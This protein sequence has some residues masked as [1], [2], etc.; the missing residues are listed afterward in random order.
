MCLGRHTGKAA[1]QY[2][3][4]IKALREY[5]PFRYT[6]PLD[7]QLLQIS[8]TQIRWIE[9]TFENVQSTF[10]DVEST[11]ENVQ[12]TFENVRLD[13][14]WRIYPSLHTPH[15]PGQSRHADTTSTSTA[16]SR[17]CRRAGVATRRLRGSGLSSSDGRAS[18]SSSSASYSPRSQ[19]PQE[20]EPI[21]PKV[22]A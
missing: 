13:S 10:E 11:V 6:T 19:M 8:F 12:S 7:I 17:P 5:N 15:T 1:S 9:S 21:L 18:V 14:P 22:P 3:H 16:S 2:I 20:Q 4:Y